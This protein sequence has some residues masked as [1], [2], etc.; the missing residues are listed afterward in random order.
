MERYL[1]FDGGC[2]ACT[3]LA[4]VIEHE[5]DGWLM[6]RSLRDSAMTAVLDEVRPGWRWEPTLV[7]VEGTRTRVYTGIQMRSRLLVGLGLRR[8]V[9][10]KK[11]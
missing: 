6:T 8:A 3:G 9:R 2:T 5:T 7:E 4:Q 10:G 11:R 1:V